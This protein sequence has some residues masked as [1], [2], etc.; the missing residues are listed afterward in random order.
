MMLDEVANGIF[1][2]DGAAVDATA[3]YVAGRDPESAPLGRPAGG[4]PS[5]ESDH[6]SVAETVA[7]WSFT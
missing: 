1:Q 6:L 7:D 4:M 2:L 5:R 3:D